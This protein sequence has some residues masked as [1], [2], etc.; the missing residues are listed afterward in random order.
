MKILTDEILF[1][2]DSFSNLE[3]RVEKKQIFDASAATTEYWYFMVSTLIARKKK[4]II[5]HA[6]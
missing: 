1:F 3:F 6:I 2:T 4:I 5:V